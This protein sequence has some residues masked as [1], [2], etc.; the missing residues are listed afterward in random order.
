MHELFIPR[1]LARKKARDEG[2]DLAEIEAQGPYAERNAYFKRLE[3]GDEEAVKFWKRVRDAKNE[4]Y[5]QPYALLNISFDNYSGTKINS[6]NIDNDIFFRM[7]TLRGGC[8]KNVCKVSDFSLGLK[9]YFVEG[10]VNGIPVEVLPDSG[11]D[12][13]FMSLELASGL[14]LGPAPETQKRIRLAN[15]KPVKSPGMVE[16]LW[17]FV[18]E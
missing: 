18:R 8:E 13:C 5:I 14:G 1:K 15:K 6:C 10:D 9:E 16:V 2:S 17:R 7:T 12:M 3:E 11:A 4:S